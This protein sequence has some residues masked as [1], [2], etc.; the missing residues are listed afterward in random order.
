MLAV[1]SELGFLWMAKFRSDLVRERGGKTDC[2][3]STVAAI[4]I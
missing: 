3:S 4:G 1:V 2:F